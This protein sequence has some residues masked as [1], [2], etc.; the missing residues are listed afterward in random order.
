MLQGKEGKNKEKGSSHTGK[1]GARDEKREGFLGVGTCG[2]EV[3]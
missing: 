3:V 1:G 2:G